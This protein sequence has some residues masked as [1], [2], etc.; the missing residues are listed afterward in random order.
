[1]VM[2]LCTM[3]SFVLFMA[4]AAQHRLMR[5][6]KDRAAFKRSANRPIIIGLVPCR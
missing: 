1:V 5:P 3:T 2:F 4:P 6:L